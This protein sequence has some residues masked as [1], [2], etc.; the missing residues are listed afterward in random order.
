MIYYFCSSRS[1]KN[2]KR[3]KVWSNRSIILQRSTAERQ[4]FTLYQNKRGIQYCEKNRSFSKILRTECQCSISV[5]FSLES[6]VNKNFFSTMRQE[7]MRSRLA[8]LTY[9][10]N[11]KR[12]RKQRESHYFAEYS[13]SHTSLHHHHHL[14]KYKAKTSP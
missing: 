12:N 13:S 1:S 7:I 9:E 3:V 8:F 4:N 11:T 2:S 5:Y 14:S 10:N 6:C